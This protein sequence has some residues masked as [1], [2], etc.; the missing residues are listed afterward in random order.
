MDC[1]F[2]WLLAL[3]DSEEIT[4]GYPDALTLMRHLR[5]MGEGNALFSRSPVCFL[6]I[7]FLAID[8]GAQSLV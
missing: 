3:V 2:L 6:D 4:I 8:L 7:R 5:A 1:A